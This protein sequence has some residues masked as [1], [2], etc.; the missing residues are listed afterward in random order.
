[1][2]ACLK[3]DHALCYGL[4]HAVLSVKEKWL[5]FR[6]ESFASTRPD[7]VSEQLESDKLEKALRD[8]GKTLDLLLMNLKRLYIISK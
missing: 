5:Q 1:M 7:A 8:E 3:L 6:A 4:Y 2:S